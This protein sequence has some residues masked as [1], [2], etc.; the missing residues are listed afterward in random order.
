MIRGRTALIAALGLA[1]ACSSA[2]TT[3]LCSAGAARAGTTACG[4]NGRGTLEQSCDGSAWVNTNACHDLDVCTDGG[5]RAGTTPCGLD[6]RGTLQQL[7]DAGQ[8][9]DGTTCN[10]PEACAGGG[11]RTGTTACGLNGRGHVPQ[12]CEQG[13]WVDVAGE[14]TDADVC[15]DAHT[16]AGTAACGVGGL[17]R[18]DQLCTSGQWVDTTTCVEAALVINGTVTGPNVD[19]QAGDLHVW[20]YD[21]PTEV[22]GYIDEKVLPAL[23]LP[24][25]AATFSFGVSRTGTYWVRAFVDASGPQF[26]ADGLPSLGD[27]PQAHAVQVEVTAAGPAQ[28]HLE[29]ELD[30]AITNRM[31]GL[32]LDAYHESATPRPAGGGTCGG[33]YLR[34]WT[35]HDATA[36]VDEPRVRLPDGSVVTLLDDGGCSPGYDNGSSSYDEHASDSAYSYGFAS[37]PLGKGSS[38]T[39]DY[40]LFY[41]DTADDLI[42]V[43]T[44]HIDAIVELESTGSLLSPGP[45]ASHHATTLRPTLYWHAS[46]G[47]TGYQVSITSPAGSSTTWTTTA[48]YP[49]ETDLL[50]QTSVLVALTPFYAEVTPYGGRRAY[51]RTVESRFV[52]DTTGTRVLTISGVVTSPTTTTDIILEG[53]GHSNRGIEAAMVLAA[54]GAYALE[55]LRPAACSSTS[56]QVSAYNADAWGGR[57]GIDSCTDSTQGITVRPR[58]AL[59]RPANVGDTPTLSWESY[60]TT[61]LD[62]TG[63]TFDASGM[64]YIL[65]V[66]DRSGG[67]AAI[68]WAL[69]PTTTSFDFASPPNDKLDVPAAMMG[70]GQNPTNLSASK[71]WVWFV[72]L[73]DCP[74]SATD[75]ATVDCFFGANI[76]VTESKDSVLAKP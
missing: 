53:T 1:S 58:V 65:G 56:A 59:H 13:W 71:E 12:T 32:E 15:V 74:F 42:H 36:Q 7:C 24:L 20:L 44:H 5:L 34:L 66:F 28:L 61:F 73:V 57:D 40:A 72:L 19:F 17:G 49:F 25:P 4:L 50:D 63:S 37:P 21:S 64:T 22:L 14:C 8:W 9:V 30:R 6:L 23:P 69:P 39:G 70:I 45:S 10:I 31:R 38:L 67:A 43:E 62:A 33:F 18:L 51:A 48:T 29:M 11:Q 46:P 3:P 41:R 47:A 68:E 75:P 35:A 55:V 26:R 76:R 54:P 52:V 27:D 16:Q 60:P 2:S